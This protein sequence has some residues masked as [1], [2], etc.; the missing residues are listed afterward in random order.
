MREQ[1]RAIYLQLQHQ[2]TFSL[3]RLEEATTSK[4][5]ICPQC[6]SLALAGAVDCSSVFHYGP[7]VLRPSHAH[8]V[9]T[10]KADE[11]NKTY[12]DSFH[13]QTGHHT[14]L[15][16]SFINECKTLHV[17]WILGALPFIGDKH[18]MYESMTW[19]MIK[20]GLMLLLCWFDGIGEAA[21]F[22]CFGT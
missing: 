12:G 11:N 20:F 17:R 8:T 15:H 3:I 21:H 22:V 5:Y 7:A 2:L 10:P 14:E 4:M 9:W 18:R 16:L 13:S 6:W 19:S 1:Y